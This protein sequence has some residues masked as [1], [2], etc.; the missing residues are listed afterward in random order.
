VSPKFYSM[1]YSSKVDEYNEEEKND[2][3]EM[4]ERLVPI[5]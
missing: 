3:S 5:R 2:Y 1:N 4:L